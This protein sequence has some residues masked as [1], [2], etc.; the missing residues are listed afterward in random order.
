MLR[1]L[2]IL[3]GSFQDPERS[4]GSKTEAEDDRLWKTYCLLKAMDIC[5]KLKLPPPPEVENRPRP[6]KRMRLE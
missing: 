2:E 1:A 6:L 4:S 3:L 5:E